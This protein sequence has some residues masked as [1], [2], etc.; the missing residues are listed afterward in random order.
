M[1][2]AVR[3]YRF[4]GAAVAVA[5]DSP[6]IADWLDEFVHPSFTP[7]TGPVDFSIR[8]RTDPTSRLPTGSGFFAMPDGVVSL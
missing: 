6:T 2:A 1:V 3:R 5:C 7:H 4:Y 8:V